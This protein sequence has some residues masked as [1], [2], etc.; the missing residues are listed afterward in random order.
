MPK[1]QA[2][3]VTTTM[4]SHGGGVALPREA[5][6]FVIYLVKKSVVTK[7]RF[8]HIAPTAKGLFNGE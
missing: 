8:T 6:F 2:P 4:R 3:A 5:L 7:V 1:R